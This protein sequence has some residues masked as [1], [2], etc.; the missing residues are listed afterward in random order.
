MK[1]CLM[2]SLVLEIGRS[3]LQ[4]FDIYLFDPNYNTITKDAYFKG[5]NN[6]LCV[7]DIQFF[8]ESFI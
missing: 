1:R 5:N 8:T 7:D 3:M 6:F 4:D 2:Y